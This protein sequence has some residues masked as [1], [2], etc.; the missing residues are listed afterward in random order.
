MVRTVA[1]LKPISVL[2]RRLDAAYADPL[3]LNQSSHIGT[4]GLVEALRAENVT[5]VNALGS[6]I[7]ETRALLAFMP[8]ICREL[9]GEELKLPSIATWW[10][11]QKSERE[12]VAAI[13]RRW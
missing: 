11:G 4:P 2:W 6:G 1:G 13:S 3:E 12:H 5:I 7:L 9:F 10:C 8:T